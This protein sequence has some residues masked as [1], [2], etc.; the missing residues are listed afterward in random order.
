VLRE[1]QHQGRNGLVHK[2]DAK[3][4]CILSAGPTTWER[5]LMWCRFRTLSFD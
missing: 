2:Y 1:A 4:L 3:T 5:S